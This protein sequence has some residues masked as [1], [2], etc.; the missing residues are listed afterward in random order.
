VSVA[1][2][3]AVCVAVS[4]AESVAES[5]AVS[6]THTGGAK[7]PV[8]RNLGPGPHLKLPATG[9]VSNSTQE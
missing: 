9:S 3:V 6:H 7:D 5:V 2:S 8:F 1:V 4:V